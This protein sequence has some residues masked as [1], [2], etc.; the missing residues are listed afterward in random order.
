MREKRKRREGRGWVGKR[1]CY[2]AGIQCT[3]EVE[4]QKRI[5][6]NALSTLTTA[7]LIG[8]LA[9]EFVS[10]LIVIDVEASWSKMFQRLECCHLAS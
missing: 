9:D 1:P 8:K 6:R 10:E 3:L 4:W 7:V 2:R 5:E